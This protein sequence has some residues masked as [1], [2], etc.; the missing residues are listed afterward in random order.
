MFTG[1]IECLGSLVDIRQ[2][3]S[4][5]HLTIHAPFTEE[6]QVDQSIAH[7]GVCLTVEDILPREESYMVTVISETLKKTNL[8]GLVLND[9]INL[10][11]SMLVNGRLD[12]HIVQGHADLVATCTQVEDANG[13][14]L[15]TFEYPGDDSHLVVNQGSICVNGVSLTVVKALPRAFSVAIIPYTRKYTNFNRIHEGSPVNI[16]FDIIGKYVAKMMN[17][18]YSS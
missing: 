4:N 10:E 16:E 13:S 7:N 8:G 1:I 6:L 2:K 12:G 11:R 5:L 15:Y 17:K 18:E 9:A 3:D 14:W